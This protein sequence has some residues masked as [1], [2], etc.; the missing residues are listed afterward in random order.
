VNLLGSVTWAFLFE[1]QPFFDGFRDLA[2]N[3]IEKPV[4]NVFRMLGRT[5]G[6]R[7][8]VESSAAVPLAT[9]LEQS[10]RGAAD[11]ATRDARSAAVLVWNYHDDNLPAPPADIE[12]TIAG[13]PD[14]RPTLTHPRVDGDRGNA[15]TRWQRMG[16]PQPPNGAQ[17]RELEASAGLAT[18]GAPGPVVVKDGWVVMPFSLPRQGVSLVTLAW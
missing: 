18:L 1:G 14:V 15:Y 5:S 4:L 7:V 2:T 11:V 12:L 3:G 9:L 17:Y 16:S 6:D 8:A 13:L 10:V